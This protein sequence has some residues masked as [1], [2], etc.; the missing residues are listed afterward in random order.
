MELGLDALEPGTHRR[1]ADRLTG[2]KCDHRYEGRVASA[3][4]IDAD[5]LIVGRETL[6]PRDAELLA[7]RARG[8]A[9]S[10]DPDQRDQDPEDGDKAFMG[11]DPARDRSHHVGQTPCWW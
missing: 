10:D 3:L 11:E 7:E 1:R 2:R 4:V 6:A 5:D 9:H 8:R